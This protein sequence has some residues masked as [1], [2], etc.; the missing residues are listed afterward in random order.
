M[1]NP[2][3]FDEFDL[4]AGQDSR[5]RNNNVYVVSEENLELVE[6]KEKVA[7]AAKPYSQYDPRVINLLRG[8]PVSDTKSASDVQEKLFKLLSINEFDQAIVNISYY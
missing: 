3:D 1:Q 7:A 8:K 2:S 4:S 5:E 6:E